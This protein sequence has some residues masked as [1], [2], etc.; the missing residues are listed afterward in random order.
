MISQDYLIALLQHKIKSP[1][2]PSG[3]FSHIVR[4]IDIRESITL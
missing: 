4:K 2:T 3:A 1:A